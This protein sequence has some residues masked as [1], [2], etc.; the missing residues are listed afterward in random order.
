MKVQGTLYIT[1]SAK[2]L[3]AFVSSPPE[4]QSQMLHFYVGDIDMSHVW[5]RV[6]SFEAEISLDEP[7]ELVKEALAEIDAQ[8]DELN[9]KYFMARQELE[10]RRANLLC[11]EAPKE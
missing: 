5:S 1:G 7:K 4:E 10:S 8:L 2:D 9:Q 6:G 3:P 11:L